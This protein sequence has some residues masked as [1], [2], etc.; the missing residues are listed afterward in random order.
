MSIPAIETLIETHSWVEPL[1]KTLNQ[2]F[3]EMYI[4]IIDERY[5]ERRVRVAHT[6]VRIKRL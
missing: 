3:R 4:G 5:I 1:Q 6:H 2:H